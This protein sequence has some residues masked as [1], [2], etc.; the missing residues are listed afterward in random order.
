MKI[1][2]ISCVSNMAAGIVQETLT[3]EDVLLEMKKGSADFRTLIKSV[4]PKM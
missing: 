1:L 2:G 3:A 4:L